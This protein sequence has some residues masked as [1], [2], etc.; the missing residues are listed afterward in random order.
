MTEVTDVAIIGGGAAGCAVAYYLCEAG[1]TS[2]II[3]R[4]GI[5]SQASGYAA[6]GLNPLTGHG[7]PGPLADFAWESFRL[8]MELYPKL[9]GSTEVDYQLRKTS[10]IM[11]TF[12]QSEVRELEELG[13]RFSEKPG[14][15]GSLADEGNGRNISIAGSREI[16]PA[17]FSRPETIRSTARTSPALCIPLPIKMAWFCAPELFEDSA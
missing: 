14:F 17:V 11:L 16:S 4:E 15:S 3:E 1:L 2:T 7:I 6:G 5:S 8:H 10:E 9:T 13:A 12:H